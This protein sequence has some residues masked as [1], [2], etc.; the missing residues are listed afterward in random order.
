MM[1][2]VLHCEHVS[3]TF[4][5][6]LSSTTRGLARRDAALRALR[7]LRTLLLASASLCRARRSLGGGCR[8]RNR[9]CNMFFRLRHAG[10]DP[11]GILERDSVEARLLGPVIKAFG[12][13]RAACNMLGTS[14]RGY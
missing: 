1:I 10:T 9:V 8:L 11:V 4:E 13:E 14:Y 7:S 5:T 3:N 6:C 2:I 12:L